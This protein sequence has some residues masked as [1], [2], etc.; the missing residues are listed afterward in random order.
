[1]NGFLKYFIAFLGSISFIV[2]IFLS[3]VQVAVYGDIDGYFLKEYIKYNVFENVDISENDLMYV[4][5]GM[6]DYLDDKRDDLVIYTTV[7]DEEREFFNERE[8]AHM[9]DVKNLF[10]SGKSIRAKCLILTI[11]TY[12]LVILKDK[13]FLSTISKGFLGAFTF[14]LATTITLTAIISSNFTKYFTIFHQIFFDN[15]LW[16]L[17]PK[18]DLLINIVPEG[19][20]VDTAIRIGS[21]FIFTIMAISVLS[22]VLIFVDRKR[23]SLWK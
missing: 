4:T 12:I 3:S 6:L 2:A 20:F 13:S 16:L 8:K 18:K 5:Y 21:I 17:N 1:M 11:F 19:F 7:N 23:R 9:Y 14:V 10:N 22:V 15:D